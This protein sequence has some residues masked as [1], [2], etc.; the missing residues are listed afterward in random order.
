[1]NKPL[2]DTLLN[3]ASFPTL[4]TDLE[5]DVCIIG[6]GITGIT[7]GYLLAKEGKKVVV[8]DKNSV[9]G[10]ESGATTA[11]LTYVLDDRYYELEELHH[12]ETAN[13]I[14]KSHAE[15]IDTIE[16]I[17]KKENIDCDFERINGYL[18]LG[19]EDE[20]K[21]LDKELETVHKLGHIEVT[22]GNSSDLFTGKIGPHLKFP[23]QAQFHPLKYLMGLSQCIVKNDGEIYE[24]VFAT[25]VEETENGVEVTL[26]DGKIIRAKSVIVATNTPFNDRLKMHTKQAPYRSYV[27]AVEIPKNVLEKALYWDTEDP[28]HYVR[29]Y[30]QAEREFL[31]I[32]G[33]DHKTGQRN[34]NLD[35]FQELLRW[36]QVKFPLIDS[37]IKYQ[38]SG[39]VLEPMDGVAF[40]GLNPGDKNTYI[41]TGY[42][43]SGMTYGTIA[44]VLLTDLII[45]KTNILAKLYDPARKDLHGAGDF[46]KENLN[47]AKQ[48]VGA[49]LPQG[50]KD[51]VKKPASETGCVVNEGLQKVAVYKNKAGKVCKYSAVCP[52][53]G[54][55]VKWNDQAKSFDCPC[56][57]SRFDTE[58]KV[59]NGPAKKGLKPLH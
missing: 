52:H 59:L 17:A 1:M 35:P 14:L 42:S 49:L 27:I 6:A 16:S 20:E 57:G 56:H 21:N 5:T 54:C 48:Y 34:N 47:V 30:S 46:L 40:I 36:T 3:K 50:D 58:G 41:G 2:W 23:N 53:L 55:I 39:Q 11:H 22:K 4:T 28:Y 19:I 29:F 51:D 13:L 7:A 15:A 9:G 10:G 25:D 33:E 24:N 12:E 45:G 32:G 31:I 8:I 26:E 18:F 37:K 43:G 44:G 38:W